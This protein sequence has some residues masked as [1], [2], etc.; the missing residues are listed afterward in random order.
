MCPD[1]LR[2]VERR[3]Q[4]EVMEED[5]FSTESD[6]LR[7]PAGLLAPAGWSARSSCQCR[8]PFWLKTEKTTAHTLTLSFQ[9]H[10]LKYMICVYFAAAFW[11]SIAQKVLMCR[12]I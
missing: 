10:S 2:A 11:I 5:I 3:V 12:H 6:S 1:W 4:S 9:P 7:R 8:P